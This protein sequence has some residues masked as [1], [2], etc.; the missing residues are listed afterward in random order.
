M[1]SKKRVPCSIKYPGVFFTEDSYG[2]RVYYIRYRRKSERKLIEEKIKFSL[3][4]TPA[5]AAGIRS[6]RIYGKELSNR[7]TRA[8]RQNAKDIEAGKFTIDRLWATYKEARP[9]LKAIK[10]DDY[11]YQK[12]LKSLFG[13]KE[14]KE[15]L[16]LDVDRLRLTLGKTRSPQTV[17]HVLILL[18]RIVNHGVKKGLST[19]LP[20][21]VQKPE[22]HN[23][24]TED[25]TDQQIRDLLKAIDDDPNILVGNMLKLAL[26]TGMRRGEIFK[27]KWDDI[28]FRR[29][30]IA[31]RNP[32]G[33]KDAVIPM[34]EPAQALLEN[35]PKKK[36]PLVFPTHDGK[37]HVT[38]QNQVR[39]I[40]E[41]AG[42]PKDFRPFHGLRH[43]FAS[44]LASSGKID[45]YTLQKL[46]THKSPLMTQ[47]YSH[48]RDEAVKRAATVVGDLFEQVMQA[49]KK[50]API[51]K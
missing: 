15:I 34:S 18:D 9:D 28:D 2:N 49:E 33:G 48:L 47:R 16:Q 45:M 35:I 10:T 11:R 26:F 4:M 17:K 44:M 31:I 12:H 46:L 21:K 37:Q 42:L 40:R 32:K 23:I 51:K 38:V 36:G 29:G 22:V 20:F 1:P 7:E 13:D 19:A 3:D 14:P 25:L 8:E 6:D 5:K 39:R 27:L 43:V 41:A 24:K 50:I 30:H